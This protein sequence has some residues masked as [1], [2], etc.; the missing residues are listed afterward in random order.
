[1]VRVLEQSRAIDACLGSWQQGDAYVGTDIP[2]LHLAD[3][4]HPLSEQARSMAETE[5]VDGLEA[6]SLVAVATDTAGF[7]VISQT[8]DIIRSSSDRPFVEIA[9]LQEVGQTEMLL[10]KQ[11]RTTRLAF[12]PALEDKRLVANLDVTMTIEKSVLARVNAKTRTVRTTQEARLFSHILA[13]RFDRF[14]F[15]DDFVTAVSA[16][17]KRIKDKYGKDSAEGRLY[18]S[19]REIRILCEPSWDDNDSKLTFIFI[20]NSREDITDINTDILDDL[21]TKF[22]TVGKYKDPDVIPTSLTDI[23]AELYVVSERLELDF[24]SSRST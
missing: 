2:F 11:G 1:M 16:I 20:F 15:P 12:L 8:C 23:T 21:M 22:K 18:P 6:D 9:V 19:I 24:L 10:A 17:Q 5:Q 4:R 7:V 3:L 14:A 13:R